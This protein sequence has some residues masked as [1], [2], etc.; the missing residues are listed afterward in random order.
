MTPL[1]AALVFSAGLVHAEDEAQNRNPSPVLVGFRGVG[2]IW[3]DQFIVENYRSSRFSGAGFVS[4][5]ITSFLMTEL[6]LGYMRTMAEGGRTITHQN[7][8]GQVASGALEL[9]PV[10]ASVVAVKDLNRAEAFF[11][12]GFAMAVFTERTDAATVA[13]AKPGFDLRSGIRVHTSFVQP[14]YRPH[15]PSG[16]DGIDVELMVGRRKHQAFD[17]GS[18]FDFSAWR[19]GAG[20]VAR[21]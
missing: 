5:G 15:S 12:A 4:Y 3:Q 21:F 14:S 18:G 20:I 7:Q 17:V 11:G 9:V 16:V 19:I 10:T 6:E 8:S 13:G 2:E 1:F